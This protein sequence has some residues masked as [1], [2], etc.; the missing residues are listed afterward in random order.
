MQKVNS[1]TK[2]LDLLAKRIKDWG[3]E[4]GFQQVA[5]IEP[6]LSQASKHLHSWLSNGFNGSMEWMSSHG[7]KRYIIA[8]LVQDAVRVICVRFDYLNDDKMIAVL[9]SNDK[10][11]ISRYAL[12]RDYHKVLR[13]R[14]A[15][16]VSNIR[17]ALPE[18]QL[19]QRAFVDSA[20]V[21][22]KPL[23]EQAGIGWMGKNTLILNQ[24]AGSFFFLGEIYTS[25]PLPADNVTQPNRCGKCRACITACPTNAFPKPYVLDARKCISY[26][27][28]EHKG[29]IPTKL[30]PLMGNR[31]FGC[32]DC[33]IICPWNKDVTQSKEADFAPRHNLDSSDLVTLFNWNKNEFI[34]KTE[35][36]A[37]RRV[38]YEM[39]RRNLAI[40]L[41]NADGSNKILDV[42]EQSISTLSPMVKEHV[43][44]AIK[45]QREKLKAKK[46]P[47]I[48]T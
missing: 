30:R 8:N 34:E 24:T 47:F 12:G 26:L 40:G 2:N 9:R 32:D 16:L 45:R 37:I 28:I 25:L 1:N 31:V 33:Q 6:D 5:I 23:A 46:T 18:M 36:M 17:T 15:R 39:W 19:N 7:E 41:G 43:I 22:E 48:V 35:G 20:P 3:T 11:Y 42:L 4:L 27:T 10:A 44:W 13:R 29:S 14:L 38:S 21:M